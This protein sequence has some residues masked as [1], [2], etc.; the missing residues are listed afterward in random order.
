MKTLF[1]SC[2]AIIELRP[3]DSLSF[4]RKVRLKTMSMRYFHA[5]ISAH[6]QRLVALSY[7]QENSSLMDEGN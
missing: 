2:H 6:R 7:F 5:M 4:A 3:D 1:E